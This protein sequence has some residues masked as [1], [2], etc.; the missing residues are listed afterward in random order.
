MKIDINKVV[1]EIANTALS[2][3]NGDRSRAFS[4]YIRLMYR[5]T[6]SLS[7]R[8][9]SKDLKAWYDKYL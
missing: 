1:P 3:A 8:C 4:E 2:Y 7:P 6:G 9:N 5:S